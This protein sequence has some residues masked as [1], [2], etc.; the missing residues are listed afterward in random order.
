[1]IYKKFAKKRQKSR[2]YPNSHKMPQLVL[3]YTLV[4]LH[5]PLLRPVQCLFQAPLQGGNTA[6]HLNL[7][8]AAVI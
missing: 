4:K 2:F 5:S 1:M 8:C 3:S 7:V 6:E